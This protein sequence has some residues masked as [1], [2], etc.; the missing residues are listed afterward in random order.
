MTHNVIY[1]RMRFPTLPKL[2]L[3]LT[4][5]TAFSPTA[6][7]VRSRRIVKKSTDREAVETARLQRLKPKAIKALSTKALSP[8]AQKLADALKERSKVQALQDADFQGRPNKKKGDAL[9]KFGVKVKKATIRKAPEHIGSRMESVSTA[10]ALSAD[11]QV[12]ASLDFWDVDFPVYFDPEDYINY[13]NG[14]LIDRIYDPDAD[15]IEVEFDFVHMEDGPD[16]ITLWSQ[17]VECQRITG[18]HPLGLV[19]RRCPGNTVEIRVTTDYSISGLSY[20][21][22]EVVGY[23]GYAFVGNEDPVAIARAN[24]YTV[25]VGERV[26]FDANASYDPDDEFGDFI[27]AYYWD[28]D[29]PD[30]PGN[31][32]SIKNPWHE[33]NDPG[34]YYVQLTVYDTEDGEDTH[35]IIIHVADVADPV[36]G[37][38]TID[39]TSVTFRW[40]PGDDNTDGYYVALWPGNRRDLTCDNGAEV[41]KFTTQKTWTGLTPGSEYTLILCAFNP[42][43]FFSL[44]WLITVRTYYASPGITGLAVT[45]FDHDSIDFSWGPANASTV[46]YKVGF[47]AGDIT[48]LACTGSPQTNTADFRNTLSP[49]TLYTIAVCGRNPDNVWSSPVRIKQ[50]TAVLPPKDLANTSRST[51]RLGFSWQPGSANT[52]HYYV[53]FGLADNP[54]LTC[55]NASDQGTNNNFLSLD[56]LSPNTEYKI[57]VCS[58]NA[59]HNRTASISTIVRTKAVVPEIRL[60]IARLPDAS[61]QITFPAT[62]NVDYVL[63]YTTQVE[64]A[65]TAATLVPTVSRGTGRFVFVGTTPAPNQFFRVEGTAR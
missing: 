61:Y 63:K 48:N 26:Y 22:F 57:V 21:G 16:Y 51:S 17:G 41:S 10:T 14:V 46:E 19:S 59:L 55:A 35:E 11:L 18:N 29:D 6:E 42:A 2:T 9:E 45:G 60:T 47:Q 8:R 37:T 49:G 7:A 20:D 4:L 24:D 3:L 50:M 30:N 1:D 64:G 44:G 15:F 58:G 25:G 36:L 53:A 52:A 23:T 38:T 65:F 32:T 28:F 39:Q 56:N 13:M 27:E 40:G 34:T 43:D 62:S 5:V 12:A 31:T 54:A 33:F